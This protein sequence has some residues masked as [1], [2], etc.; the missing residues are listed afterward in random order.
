MTQ[1]TN[2]SFYYQ[3]NGEVFTPPVPGMEAVITGLCGYAPFQ[4]LARSHGISPDEI[5]QVYAHRSGQSTSLDLVDRSGKSTTIPIF[6]GTDYQIQ[7]AVHFMLTAEGA[8]NFDPPVEQQI[9]EPAP[10][11]APAPEP[12]APIAP[13]RVQPIAPAIDPTIQ[14]ILDTFRHTQEQHTAQIQA[15]ARAIEGQR[16]AGSAQRQ[17]PFNRRRV[18]PVNHSRSSSISPSS[19]SSSSSNDHETSSSSEESSSGSSSSSAPALQ[20]RRPPRRDS[21]ILVNPPASPASSQSNRSFFF[22]PSESSRSGSISSRSV[23]ERGSI[24][25]D[26]GH[27]LDPIRETLQQIQGQLNQLAS[28]PNQLGSVLEQLQNQRNALNQLRDQVQQLTQTLQEQQNQPNAPEEPQLHVLP[29]DE[30]EE[31]GLLRNEV[32]QIAAT[33]QQIQDQLGNDHQTV[34][35]EIFQL[36]NGQQLLRNDHALLRQELNQMMDEFQAISLIIQNLGGAQVA[37]IEDP[38]ELSPPIVP[39][40]PQLGRP[41]LDA[42]HIE[43]EDSSDDEEA[44]LPIFPLIGFLRGRTAPAAHPHRPS[45]LD[46]TRRV[47]AHLKNPSVNGGDRASSCPFNR[48]IPIPQEPLRSV[49]PALRL[50]LPIPRI[51]PAD[52]WIFHQHQNQLA[53]ALFM[54][55]IMRRQESNH[56]MR[57]IAEPLIQQNQA[58]RS[59]LAPLFQR[60]GRI[61]LKGLKFL[62][63]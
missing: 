3:Q 60:I 50:S 12:S 9:P 4:E 13:E 58:N 6:M 26:P 47:L 24:N 59:P 30:M 11:P 18:D 21:P 29:V 49:A 62:R 54:N 27:A 17:R 37:V 48:A 41:P 23:E 25:L 35:N 39:R 42:A 8:P 1:P 28:L 51:S 10:E 5:T 44:P 56:P 36:R 31:L 2:P 57:E 63:R 33:L 14:T 53:R 20:I 43:I 22:I 40:S 55:S 52:A 46:L 7:R 19:S 45:G 32:G 16:R 61:A 38:L 15:L 34:L